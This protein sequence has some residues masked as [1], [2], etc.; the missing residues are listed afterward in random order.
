MNIGMSSDHEGKEC[1][2]NIFRKLCDKFDDEIKLPTN[3]LT[4]LQFNS[5]ARLKFNLLSNPFKKKDK[6]NELGLG[7]DKWNAIETNAYLRPVLTHLED[8][9]LSQLKALN[10]LCALNLRIHKDRLTDNGITKISALIASLYAIIKFSLEQ[11]GTT[12]T[13]SVFVKFVSSDFFN[14]VLDSLLIGL[15]FGFYAMVLLY[16]GVLLP[17]VR[18]SQM[19]MDLV[20]VAYIEK[21]SKTNPSIS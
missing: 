7:L 3:K 2:L 20:Q 8:Y 14:V 9:S 19:V 18:K 16:V 6:L 12:S 21:E 13:F 17:N 15:A 11:L 4:Y 10:K 1:I 5:L